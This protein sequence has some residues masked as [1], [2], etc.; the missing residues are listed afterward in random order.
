MKAKNRHAEKFGPFQSFGPYRPVVN[1]QK[2]REH[3]ILENIPSLF[4][5]AERRNLSNAAK[6][7]SFKSMLNSLD[8]DKEIRTFDFVG[9]GAVHQ[10]EKNILK[11]AEKYNIDPDLTRA[12]MYAENARGWYGHAAE[13]FGAS[14]S[15]L[16]MNIQKS[17]WS[18]LVDR[19]PEE[20]YNPDTNIEAGTI[21]LKRIRDR[22]EEPTPEKIAS[23]WHFMGNENIDEFGSYVGRVYRQKPWQKLE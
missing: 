7:L 4:E 14:E 5:I 10:Y 22:I 16:P 9:K 3:S 21:L 19:K 23:V 13:T 2:Y 17:R 8:P 15:I 11:Y 1:E 6:R 18:K 12:V 20:M